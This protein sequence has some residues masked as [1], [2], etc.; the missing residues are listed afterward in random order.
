MRRICLGGAFA[1]TLVAGVTLGTLI[2]SQQVEAQPQ[3]T[4][5]GDAA[6]MLHFIKPGQAQAYEGVMGRLGEALQNSQNTETNRQQQA[7]GWKVYRAELD[8]TGQGGVMYAWVIDP[9]VGGAN[10]AASTILSE[11]FPP[12]L[13]S[14]TR[15]TTARLQMVR[16][17]CCRSI[18]G[19]SRTSS[20]WYLSP[21]KN[22][23]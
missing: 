20:L 23:E 16:T 9:V 19:W 2:P 5:P 6:V 15:P 11:V 8:I 18:S 14:F 13:S 7:Q 22:D 17:S 21:A 10:Y 3:V 4:F 1:A 12:R